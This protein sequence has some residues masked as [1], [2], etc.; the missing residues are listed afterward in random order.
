MCTRRLRQFLTKRSRRHSAG[1]RGLPRSVISVSLANWVGRIQPV[2]AAAA[3]LAAM[4]KPLTA[5]V[6]LGVRILEYQ[7]FTGLLKTDRL[8]FNRG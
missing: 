3:M 6:G 5:L 4:N 1:H 8:K 2:P 7:R